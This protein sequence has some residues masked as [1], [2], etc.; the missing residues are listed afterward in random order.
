MNVGMFIYD[1]VQALDVVGP[2]DVFASVNERCPASYDLFT[3]SLDGKSVR[4][5]NGLQMTPSF[6]VQDAPPMDTFLIAG[7]VGS[8]RMG[9]NRE[10]LEWVSGRAATARRVVSICTGI[11]ILA[12]TGLLDA[13]R[14][15][16]HW[17][18]AEDIKQ[19]YPRIHMD[20]DLLFV[21]DGKFYTSGGLCAGIDLALSLVE[22]DR[23]SGTALE[24]ARNLVMYMK[25]PGNQAQ[26]SG[27][28]AAQ[29]LGTGRLAHVVEWMLDHLHEEI[30]VERLADVSAMSERNFRRSFRDTFDLSPAR[31]LEKLRLEQACLLLTSGNESIEGIA[32][33]T[34]FGGADVLRRSF[35]ARY[36]ATP[37]EYRQRFS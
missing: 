33:A 11:Y 35:R 25:R 30:T 18:F 34:G 21:D 29:G 12:A 28:L 10:L 27:P 5:E 19:K 17:A 4:A 8:R 9:Q 7:G 26:F 1:D 37:L 3:I 2:L 14:A 20:A 6:S 36:G 32:R 24:V 31:F 23:G 16:T 15:T 22:A 13:R